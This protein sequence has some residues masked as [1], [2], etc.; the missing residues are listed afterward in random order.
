MFVSVVA[1]AGMFRHDWA[2]VAAGL[3]V[4][5]IP[6]EAGP[7]GVQWTL[8][9]MGGVGGTLTVLCYGYWIRESGRT[10]PED[11]RLCRLDLGAAYLGSGLF[12]ADQLIASVYAQEYP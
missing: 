4:P 7:D 3:V 2:A 6:H 1:A 9:L 10:G 5:R 8:A 11:L 12:G